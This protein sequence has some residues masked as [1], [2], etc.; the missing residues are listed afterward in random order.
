MRRGGATAPPRLS[1]G[2]MLSPV[3]EAGWYGTDPDGP[4]QP[5]VSGVPPDS[6]NNSPINAPSTITTPIH[7]IV[8]ANPLKNALAESGAESPA[9]GPYTR[10][11]TTRARKG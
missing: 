5:W 1:L 7:F 11:Q 2:R 10:L 8:S 3:A 9:N 6:F 4:E